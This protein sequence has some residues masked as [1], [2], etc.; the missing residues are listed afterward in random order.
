[1]AAPNAP[2][3]A[4]TPVMSLPALSLASLKAVRVDLALAAVFLVVGAVPR[5]VLL[6]DIPPGLHGDEAAFGLEARRILDEGIGAWSGVALGTHRCLSVGSG[7]W[8]RTQGDARCGAG[9]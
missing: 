8:S 5:L 9:A 6:G 1:M 7:V 2:Q 4:G 3:P